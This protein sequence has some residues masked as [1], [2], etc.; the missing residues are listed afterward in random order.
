MGN[1]TLFIARCKKVFT[2]F[3]QGDMIAVVQVVQGYK[4]AHSPTLLVTGKSGPEDDAFQSSYSACG[5]S[6]FRSNIQ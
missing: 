6:G 1:I 4:E 3:H 5:Q 2:S